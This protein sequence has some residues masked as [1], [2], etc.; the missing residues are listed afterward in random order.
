MRTAPDRRP[1][2]RR[3][4]PDGYEFR[5]DDESLGLAVLAAHN[6]AVRRRRTRTSRP[7][8]ETTWKQWVTGSHTFR[9]A[10]S[11]VV[12]PAGS[13]QVVGYVTSHE[14]DALR[15]RPPAGARPTSARS[16]RCREHR[17]RG[18][19]AAMLG[20]CLATY[21]AAGLRRGVARRGL[22]EPVR[23]ARRLPALRVRGR[24]PLDEPLP[25]VP[26]DRRRR[27]R[28]APGCAARRT[29]PPPAPARPAAGRAA[30][31]RRAPPPAPG[32]RRTG[33]RPTPGR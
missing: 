14:F 1:R 6:A 17:G 3:R 25:T 30:P 26:S 22:G 16:A 33:S 2:R 23:G 12:V 18:L 9:P 13:E 7:W 27:R 31:R 15:R 21:A 4:S 24:V 8:T 32:V 19:A 20:H 28:R 29:S 10:S 5:P 11:V